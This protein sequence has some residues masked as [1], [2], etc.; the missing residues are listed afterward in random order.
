MSNFEPFSWTF[1]GFVES[2][3]NW[4]AQ[5][6]KMCGDFI[7]SSHRYNNERRNFRVNS[8]PRFGFWWRL[9][10]RP[11]PPSVPMWQ[12]TRH[13][14][15]SHRPRHHWR[16]L[17]WG[18]DQWPQCFHSKYLGYNHKNAQICVSWWD[19]NHQMFRYFLTWFDYNQKRCRKSNW[20]FIKFPLKWVNFMDVETLSGRVQACTPSIDPA[21][22]RHRFPSGH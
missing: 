20:F 9:D 18:P 2:L 14:V 4:S 16:W 8:Y 10:F 6:I 1:F 13:R 21:R 7:A 22:V 15:L 5:R 3:S 11:Y 17:R 19:S 12:G